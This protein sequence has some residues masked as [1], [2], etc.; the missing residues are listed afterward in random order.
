M[1]RRVIP[2]AV[3]LRSWLSLSQWVSPSGAFAWS[4]LKPERVSGPSA[5]SPILRQGSMGGGVSYSLSYIQ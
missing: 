1:A 3:P 5:G 4:L 2:P